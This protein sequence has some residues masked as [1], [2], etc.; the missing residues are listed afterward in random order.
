MM[1]F[2]W[3]SAVSL[4]FNVSLTMAPLANRN[5]YCRDVFP[6]LAIAIFTNVQVKSKHA[7]GTGTSLSPFVNWVLIFQN[8]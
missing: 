1:L 6:L 2:Q 7:L 3:S 5:K 4:Q 8:E